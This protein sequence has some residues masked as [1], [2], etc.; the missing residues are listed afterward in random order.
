VAGGEGN[1]RLAE[2]VA[3]VAWADPEVG[4]G[5]DAVP[6]VLTEVHH[7]GAAQWREHGVIEGRA[8]GHVGALDREVVQHHRRWRRRKSR[9]GPFTSSGWLMFAACPA[10]G[11]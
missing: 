4:L 9:S 5:R 10:P 6:D 3:G 2:P 8:G 1:V 7:A 11:M